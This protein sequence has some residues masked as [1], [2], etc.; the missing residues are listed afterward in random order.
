MPGTNVAMLDTDA[1]AHWSDD[2]CIAAT[3][4]WTHAAVTA[5]RAG[6]L[7][8]AR[9]CAWRAVE[10]G[11][12]V[13]ERSGGA[14]LLARAAVELGG[15]WVNEH[16]C[17]VER[18]QVLALQRRA[19][20]ALNPTDSLALR[21]RARIAAEEAY[22]TGDATR[23]VELVDEA[24]PRGD[25]TA[26]A[27]VLSL[28]HHCML[29]PQHGAARRALA[30]ELI[31]VSACSGSQ[32]DA[33][34]GLAWRTVD[35]F[36]EGDARA[37]RSLRELKE[38]LMRTP[39]AAVDYLVA[40]LEVMLAIRDG[41]L[42]E[43]EQLADR[44]YQAGLE[45]GDADAF[46]WYGAQLIAIRWYQGRSDEILPMVADLASSPTLTEPNDGF[47]A[48]V[49][50]LAAGAGHAEEARG[51]LARLRSDGLGRLR[52]LEHVDG[53]GCGRGR[54][55]GDARRRRRGA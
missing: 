22:A 53:I 29:G 3:R 1:P 8:D 23:V 31:A 17:A 41:R 13:S 37:D 46:G 10:A 35:L 20:A 6:R 9:R 51:A 12:K 2:P 50:V 45:V 49:A 48:A 42:A 5:R 14:E 32:T 26:T 19:L 15:V 4:R 55:G 28:A 21:L 18:L 30:D 38:R 16:R 24:R 39:F 44:C 7:D 47:F 33:V 43:A 52:Q 25:L 40:A 36:L 34:M 27:E 11:T 54:S